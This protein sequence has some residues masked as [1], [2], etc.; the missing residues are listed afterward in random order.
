L[1]GLLP[2][3]FTGKGN[4]VGV[5]LVKN[6]Q[7][8]RYSVD[9]KLDQSFINLFGRRPAAQSIESNTED[10]VVSA[11]QKNKEAANI[12]NAGN[13]ES[14]EHSE[15][16]SDSEEDNDADVQISDRD[17]DLREEV[18]FRDGRLRRRA[19]SANFQDDVDEEVQTFPLVS[20]L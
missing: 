8:T 11:S 19:V 4:D 20:Y 15:G 3:N 5:A 16:S 12:S 17:V 14:N 9:E 6:L 13:M 7:N 10:N 1:S 2:F 18:E